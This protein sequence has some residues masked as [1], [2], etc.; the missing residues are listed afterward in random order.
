MDAPRRVCLPDKRGF[1]RQEPDWQG[2]AGIARLGCSGAMAGEGMFG[3]FIILTIA[4]LAI[5]ALLHKLAT[6]VGLIQPKPPVTQSA[7]QIGNTGFRLTKF[8]VAMLCLVG[9]YLLWG[10][11]QIF[12]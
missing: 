5:G 2:W 8:N 9:L 1:A 12:R 7:R 11:T 3:K 6:R 10:A 4:I